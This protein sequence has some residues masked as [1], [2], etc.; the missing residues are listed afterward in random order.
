M[1][2][3]QALQDPRDVPAIIQATVVPP[4]QFETEVF[5]HRDHGTTIS[6]CAVLEDAL[7][8]DPAL[9][10]G[11]DMCA[12]EITLRWK[13]GPQ[14]PVTTCDAGNPIGVAATVTSEELLGQ[15]Q[16]LLEEWRL[17]HLRLLDSRKLGAEGRKLWPALRANVGPELIDDFQ[18]RPIQENNGE[19]DDLLGLDADTILAGRLEVHDGNELEG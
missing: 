13:H 6:A 2:L 5:Q 16:R 9:K 3:D 7:D 18:R 15:V 11:W 14:I 1:L 19:L 10:D 4:F 12:Y 17:I 8:V